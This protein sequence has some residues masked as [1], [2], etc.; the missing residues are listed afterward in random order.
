MRRSNRALGA[1]ALCAAAGLSATAFAASAANPRAGLYVGPQ[2]GVNKGPDVRLQ[3]GVFRKTTSSKNFN[4]VKLT[5]WHGTLSCQ[6][7]RT[8]TVNVKMFARRNGRKFSRTRVFSSSTNRLA[9]KFV[10]SRKLRGYA[11]IVTRGS[12]PSKRCDSGKVKF[13]ATFQP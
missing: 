3:V 13:K 5:K 2:T 7:G 12:S 6:D 9:G 4:G 8:H 1:V 11:R 10:N